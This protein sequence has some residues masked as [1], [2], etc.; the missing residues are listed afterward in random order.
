M[1]KMLL[2]LGSLVIVI[3]SLAEGANSETVLQEAAAAPKP[4]LSG[5]FCSQFYE[6]LIDV[7]KG[8]FT[9]SLC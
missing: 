1:K 5:F 9:L 3:R 2:V 6:V 7:N 4:K 8:S